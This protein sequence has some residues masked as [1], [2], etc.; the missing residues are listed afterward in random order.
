MG[1]CG[2]LWYPIPRKPSRGLVIIKGPAVLYIP[3]LPHQTT[4]RS[5]FSIRIT[6]TDHMSK[7]FMANRIGRG[8][9]HRFMW[10]DGVPHQHTGSH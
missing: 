9:C 5:T 10:G 6:F 7:I 4:S 8:S 1:Y 2:R 3:G